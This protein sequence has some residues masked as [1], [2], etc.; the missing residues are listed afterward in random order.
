MRKFLVTGA[1]GMLG[2]VVVD[3]LRDKAEIIACD[4]V[5]GSF[6]NEVRW[7]LQDLTDDAGCKAL[8]KEEAPDVVLHCAALVDVDKCEK[9]P[10]LARK[11][12]RDATASIADGVAGIGGKLVY[13]S[14]D[15]VFDGTQEGQYS[16]EAQ[17]SPLNEYA[18][19]KLQGEAFVLSLTGGL[20]LRTNIFGWTRTGRA[21]FAE[22]V[23]TGLVKQERL[24]MFTDVVF[25]PIQVAHLAEVVGRC[26][27]LDLEGLYH[28]T[29]SQQLSK[30]GFAVEVAR[31]FGL[32]TDCVVPTTVEA[33]GLSANRPKNM[34]LCN[35]KICRALDWKLPGAMEGVALWKKQYDIGFVSLIKGREMKDGYHF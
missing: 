33:K 7:R 12:N 32:S 10:E 22:W 18:K 9:R 28:A 17:P 1:A 5:Q 27:D 2:T 23:L 13:I 25:T 19:T 8:L 30:Y 11:I 34:A 3:H 26:M 21:S 15:S 29:G 31:Q 16:E 14:T 24:T 4:V 20:V 35:Q 6:E